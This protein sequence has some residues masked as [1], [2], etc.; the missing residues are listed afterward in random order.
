MELFQVKLVFVG[1]R[2]LHNGRIGKAIAETDSGNVKLLVDGKEVWTD[3]NHIA[4]IDGQTRGFIVF[5]LPTE[6]VALAA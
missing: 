5:P 1:K 3:Y 4:P 6:E 2:F